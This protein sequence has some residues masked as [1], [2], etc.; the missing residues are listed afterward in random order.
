MNFK[1]YCENVLNESVN[2]EQAI[3]SFRTP[4]KVIV[5]GVEFDL[6]F[7]KRKI[8]KITVVDAILD[9]KFKKQ[10]ISRTNYSTQKLKDF[11]D[12]MENVYNMKIKLKN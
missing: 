3:G 6:V 7:K 2:K 10:I 1:D 8:G 11:L 4:I 9:G 5:K 12:R